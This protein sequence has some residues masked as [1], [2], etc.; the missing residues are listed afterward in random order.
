MKKAIEFLR[1]RNITVDDM[2]N[3]ISELPHDEDGL[4]LIDELE[5]YTANDDFCYTIRG[6][7]IERQYF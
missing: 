5:D 6:N 1:A 4:A 2:G 7:K 3:I